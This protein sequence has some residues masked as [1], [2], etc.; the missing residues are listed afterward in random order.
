MTIMNN[1]QT[2][3][4]RSKSKNYHND[5][6]EL[7]FGLG[8]VSGRLVRYIITTVK[9]IILAIWNIFVSLIIV[10]FVIEHGPGERHVLVRT[11]K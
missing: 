7:K 2:R 10:C 1:E 4:P 5:T 8:R 3:K 9:N 11:L 6:L